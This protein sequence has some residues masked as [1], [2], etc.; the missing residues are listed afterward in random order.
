VLCFRG[1][2][3][4]MTSPLSRRFLVRVDAPRALS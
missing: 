2:L 1:E 3:L 4:D